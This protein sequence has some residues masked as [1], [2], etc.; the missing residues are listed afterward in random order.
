MIPTLTDIQAVD[1]VLTNML[2]GYK[3]ADDRFVA[4]RM[5]PDVPVEKV[6]DTFYILTKKYWFLDEM[7]ERAPGDDFA[8]GGYGVETDTCTTAQW[9]LEH[10]IPDEHRANNQMPMALEQLGL[11]W[12]AQQSLI[13]KERAWAADFMTTAIWGT[14]NT[15]DADWDDYQSGDPVTSIKT[16]KRTIN[17]ATGQLPNTLLVGEIV[18][19]ALTSHPDII[20]RLKYVSAATAETIERALASIFKMQNYYVALAIY[21]TKD[22]ALTA[23]YSPVIDDDALVCYVTPSPGIFTASAG[24]TFTW[25][26]G[27]GGG[28]VGQYRD[29]S[30]KS[31]ILQ[32]YEQW[33]QKIVASDV[34]YFFSD[35][36]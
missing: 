3:Q 34:G 35:I 5:F 31:D 7:Q 10:K 16:A 36:V 9:G 2:V 22:E 23:S 33:D 15:T 8:R 24:Y 30:V 6:S 11:Q 29:Q 27:G 26:G 12:L 18:D 32:A 20:D 17:Q 28:V 4:G 14:S 19:D 13:R 25:A 21:N 1:P